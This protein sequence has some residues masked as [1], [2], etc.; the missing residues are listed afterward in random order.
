MNIDLARFGVQVSFLCFARLLCRKTATSSVRPSEMPGALCY[1]YGP[2][3][4]AKT[5]GCCLLRSRLEI[6]HAGSATELNAFEEIA[7][8][9]PELL[10]SS[11]YFFWS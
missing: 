8:A 11:Y 7:C 3:H 4:L 10:Y 1:L 9:T 6:L 2:G 5:R